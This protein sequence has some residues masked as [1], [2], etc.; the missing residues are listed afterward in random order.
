MAHQISAQERKQL[1]LWLKELRFVVTGYRPLREA[2]VTAGGISLGE[3]HAKTMESKI[4]PG[5]FFAGEILDMDADTGGFNLQAA[6][7]TGYL[8]G[9]NAAPKTDLATTSIMG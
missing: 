5:L 3:V 2:I 6:L 9:L 8:A 1:R 4:C 7:S